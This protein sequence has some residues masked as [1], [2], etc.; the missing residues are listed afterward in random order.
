MGSSLVDSF[1]RQVDPEILSSK[2]TELSG[3]HLSDFLIRRARSAHFTIT[4]T[5]TSYSFY[6][7]N[8]TKTALIG[9]SLLCMPSGFKTC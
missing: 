5:F 9:S 6:T 7:V 8:S 2:E 4:S 3:N 1:G